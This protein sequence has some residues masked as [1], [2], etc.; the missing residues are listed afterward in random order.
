MADSF[1]KDIPK[2]NGKD[3]VRVSVGEFEGNKLL[4]IRIWFKPDK[5]DELRPTQ[6]GISISVSLYGALMEAL[7]EAEKFI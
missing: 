2:P 3:V 6:K 1:S 4:G 7:K 5:A